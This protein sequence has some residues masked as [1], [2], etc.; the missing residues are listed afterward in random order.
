[1][2]YV[3]VA[4]TFTACLQFCKN[5]LLLVALSPANFVVVDCAGGGSFPMADLEPNE[6]EMLGMSQGQLV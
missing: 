2:V 3:A 4:L 5:E 6:R 1:M